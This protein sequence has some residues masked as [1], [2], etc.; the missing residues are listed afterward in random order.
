MKLV[1]IEDDEWAQLTLTNLIKRY[2]P[3]I[4]VVGLAS[5]LEEA[6]LEITE[7]DPD[8]ILADIQL[9]DNSIFELMEK[10]ENTADY[11]FVITTS[12]ER[13]ALRAISHEVVD[14]IVKPVSIE[15]LTLSVNKVKRRL[16]AAQDN[17]VAASSEG[18]AN[19]MLGLSSMDKIE[20]VNVDAIV[21][22]QADGRYTHFHLLDGSKKTASKNLGEYEKLLPEEDFVRVH[23]SYIVNMNYVRNILKSDGYFVK[24]FKCDDV[25]PVAKRKQDAIIRYLKLKP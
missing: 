16:K 11:N 7:G 14:Y 19:R 1:I 3:D 15:S 12:H 10:L 4:E 18:V 8:F 20:V 24:L 17:R 21:Y 13:F 22:I 2:F 9:G 23:H 25:I 6:L 5:N